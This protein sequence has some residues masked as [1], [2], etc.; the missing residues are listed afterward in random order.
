[1]R[2]FLALSA[3]VGSVAAEKPVAKIVK[4]LKAM[5]AELKTEME[6]DQKSFD[7]MKCW[8]KKTKESTTTGIEDA[9]NCISE[10]Q[11]AIESATGTSAESGTAAGILEKEIQEA[12]QELAAKTAGR[13]KAAAEFTEVEKELSAAISGLKGAIVVL[14]KHN[15]FLQTNSPVLSEGQAATLRR[16]MARFQSAHEEAMTPSQR[17]VMTA[18]LE[19]P[20]FGAYSSQSGEIFGILQNMLDQFTADVKKARDDEA[21]DTASFNE[22][23]KL[24]T[25]EIE[26]K[27]TQLG[28]KNKAK[29]AADK[30]KADN[31]EKLRKCTKAE[32][33]LQA[34]LAE[35]TESCAATDEEF[36]MRTKARTEEAAAV[37]KA[38][39]FLDSPDAFA[40]FDKAYGFV[41]VSMS[42]KK[43]QLHGAMKALLKSKKAQNITFAD[44]MPGQTVMAML[45]QQAMAKTGKNVDFSKVI[46]KID[47]LIKELK[48]DMSKQV[49]DKD[50]CVGA[51]NEM[52]LALDKQKNLVA[53]L[54]SK[55]EQLVAQIEQLTAD[56]EKNAEET[57]ALQESMTAAG[58]NRSI[59]NANYQKSMKENQEAVAI[60][61]K[62]KE[63]L[64]PIFAPK[65][66]Q[67]AQK[68]AG[69]GT[70][71]KNAGGAKVLG[72]I[73]Q[74]VG[75]TEKDIAVLQ[76]TET[77][78][79][80]EYEKYV[81]T[82]NDTLD[83]LEQEKSDLDGQKADAE[84]DE[85]TTTVDLGNAVTDQ[86][87]QQTALDAKKSECKF[88]MDNFDVKQKACADEIEA[89]N[90]A[91]AFLKGMQ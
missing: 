11:G 15:S 72:M 51:I 54:T 88:L 67:T 40:A 1:M 71:E 68:P 70:Y 36:G 3:L 81:K 85:A 20:S 30:K 91:K 31:E 7:K 24:I 9:N 74:I 14:K 59:E 41:Q 76:S 19:Q 49:A 73:D 69:F 78:A 50:A 66:I 75:D 43:A 82:S 10:S 58:E 4:M 5:E 55:Q 28:E 29:A 12:Q 48:A 37:A 86:G 56:L 13:Q 57:T 17:Q 2:T 25:E 27:S 38:I 47:E 45:Q 60:L 39:E 16:N 89:M 52:S 77:A 34:V 26:A 23:K 83:A 80:A 22:A 63:V 6:R 87:N 61:K 44:L 53:K 79:Q 65:L 35:T 42:S 21:E 46:V 32:E 90:E 18:F 33:E 62:A 8:C 84:K 64:A